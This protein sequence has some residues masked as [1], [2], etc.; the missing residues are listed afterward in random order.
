MQNL[1][2]KKKYAVPALFIMAFLANT[3]VASA[4]SG[5]I[6][7]AHKYAWGRV[8]GYVN[9]APT[10]AGL[11][12][13]DS[14]L[15]GY[16]W[17]ANTGW[18]NFSAAQGGVTNDGN[19]TLGGYAWDAGGGWVSFT[20]VT[21]DSDGLFHGL[22]TGGTV[23]GGTYAINFDCLNCD[24]RTTWRPAS[25]YTTSGSSS[26]YG[27]ISPII[28][29]STPPNVSS[30]VT[31]VVT[32]TKVSSPSQP[33]LN[34]SG[35]NNPNIKILTSTTTTTFKNPT[36]SSTTKTATTTAKKT[37]VSSS[38]NFIHSVINFIFSIVQSIF[39][40]IATF[41]RFFFRF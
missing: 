29:T 39:A 28:I 38:S 37:I 36:A 9:F 26:G 32:T 25:S 33:T 16:A 21:I 5:N 19:G 13:T 14:A 35:K 1:L 41:F 6:D 22:A 10:N 15:T 31:T 27:S 12:V 2:N 17:G 40:G 23:N 30:T 8:A 34:A 20:G 18:I 4:S 11:T 7:P 24:V 3:L